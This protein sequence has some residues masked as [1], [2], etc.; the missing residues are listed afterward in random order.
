ML[1]LATKDSVLLKDSISNKGR[2]AQLE[3]LIYATLKEARL[4]PTRNK[5]GPDFNC[6]VL[7]Q[8]YSVEVK[9]IT[10]SNPDKIIEG[11]KTARAQIKNSKK[12]GAIILD[13][14]ASSNPTNEPLKAFL[15]PTE[16]RKIVDEYAIDTMERFIKP[17]QENLLDGSVFNVILRCYH[18]IPAGKNADEF[19]PWTVLIRWH[20]MNTVPEGGRAREISE[21]FETSLISK[22]PT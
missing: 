16:Y 21:Y 12:P 15:H 1:S 3:L 22:L 14:S 4:S 13:F 10:S 7:G 9:R 17:K 2:N 5:T 20:T 8:T 18:Q 6:T 19:Y 11:I